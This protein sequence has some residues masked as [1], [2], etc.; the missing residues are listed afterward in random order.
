MNTCRM[1]QLGK[2]RGWVKVDGKK[3]DID[4]DSWRAQRDHSWGIRMGVG[5]PEQGVQ[6]P[7]I[8]FFA[9]LMINWM[10]A[11]F[12]DLRTGEFTT[13]YSRKQMGRSN[14]CQEH[15]FMVSEMTGRQSRWWLWTTTLSTTLIAEG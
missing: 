8:S 3:Y 12:E 2:A 13:T 14:I 11:Q 10:T 4:E 1:A 9:N 6:S 15:W 7:D 5:A